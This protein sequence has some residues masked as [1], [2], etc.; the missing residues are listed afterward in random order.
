MDLLQEQVERASLSCWR[1]PWRELVQRRGSV[2][3]PSDASLMP[4]KNES[5]VAITKWY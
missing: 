3:G 5:D 1:R 2:E 4:E